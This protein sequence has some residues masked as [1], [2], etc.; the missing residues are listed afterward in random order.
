MYASNKRVYRLM[1][2]AQ[3]DLTRQDLRNIIDY[4]DGE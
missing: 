2:P 1:D 4:Y 3:S